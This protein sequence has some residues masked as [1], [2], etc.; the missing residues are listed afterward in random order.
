VLNGGHIQQVGT[1]TQIYDQPANAFVAGFIGESNL[2][3]VQVQHCAQGVAHLLAPGGEPFKA[4]ARD[5]QAG[6]RVQY[7]LRPEH[8]HLDSPGSDYHAPLDGVVEQAIF[9]GKD[10]EINL[11]TATGLRIKAL[12]RDAARNGSERLRSGAPLR[13]WYAP[14]HAFVLPGGVTA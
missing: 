1:P 14:A 6:Q 9:I 2:F 10:F 8:L 3:D 4:L 11:R 5:L 13:L 7:L 12:V